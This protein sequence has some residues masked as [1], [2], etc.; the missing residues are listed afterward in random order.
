LANRHAEVQAPC[1]VMVKRHVR[2]KALFDGIIDG[3]LAARDCCVKISL[4]ALR[5]ITSFFLG[6]VARSIGTTLP[7]LLKASS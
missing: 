4:A 2:H 1:G 5:R 6:S 3:V 7:L